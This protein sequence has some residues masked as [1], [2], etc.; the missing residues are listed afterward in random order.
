MCIRDRSYGVNKHAR[1][2]ASCYTLRPVRYAFCS[3]TSRAIIPVDIKRRSHSQSLQ[4]MVDASERLRTVDDSVWIVINRFLTGSIVKVFAR[5]AAHVTRTV[6]HMFGTLCRC[7]VIVQFVHKP[8][9]S[10]FGLLAD[11]KLVMSAFCAIH[12][13]STY[14]LDNNGRGRRD[15]RTN[16]NEYKV[17]L[18]IR[19]AIEADVSRG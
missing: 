4:V 5:V 2:T 19:F 3:G 16:A 8:F 1:S 6:G 18:L 7:G 15:F 14:G 12:G 11:S 10:A 17:E 9:Q 13:T